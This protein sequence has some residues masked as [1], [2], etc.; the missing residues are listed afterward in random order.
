MIYGPLKYSRYLIQFSVEILVYSSICFTIVFNHTFILFLNLL[1]IMKHNNVE[2]L[3]L[4]KNQNSI[5][6]WHTPRLVIGCDWLPYKNSNVL[7]KTFSVF[8]DSIKLIPLKSKL[9]QYKVSKV[10]E[11]FI[12]IQRLEIFF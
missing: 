2:H 4:G 8:A 1:Y 5:L 3:E 10:F 9:N 6:F 7:N 11:K 12:H